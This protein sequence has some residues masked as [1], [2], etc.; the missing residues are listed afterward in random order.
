MQ[1]RF[2]DEVKKAIKRSRVHKHIVRK[3]R[4]WRDLELGIEKVRERPG[5][6]DEPLRGDRLGQRFIRLNQQWRAFYVEH[7][8]GATELLEAIEVNPHE[9]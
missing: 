6:H 4:F 5:F 2:S 9:Y 7:K 3:L 1:V 8:D